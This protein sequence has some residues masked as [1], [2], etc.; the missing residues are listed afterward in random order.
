MQVKLRFV[1]LKDSV[2]VC[3][4]QTAAVDTRRPDYK[5]WELWLLGDWVLVNF[6]KL[7]SLIPVAFCGPMEPEAGWELP[8]PGDVRDQQRRELE[9]L[10]N[11][12]HARSAIE[13]EAVDRAAK[14]AVRLVLDGGGTVVV[15]GSE[16]GAP[17]RRK[18]GPKPK[19][20]ADE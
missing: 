17:A 16:T 7:Q 4:K 1:K 12:L 2:M 8:K 15:P 19:N 3:N 5:G 10:G 13:S 14:E 20:K 9:A 18:P 11:G 6:G